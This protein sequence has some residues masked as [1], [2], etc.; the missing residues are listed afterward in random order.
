MQNFMYMLKRMKEGNQKCCKTF[1]LLIDKGTF[2]IFMCKATSNHCAIGFSSS[3]R[4]DMSVENS[5]GRACGKVRGVSGQHG[6]G[7]LR[8]S[9]VIG[10]GPLKILDGKVVVMQAE[11]SVPLWWPTNS[12]EILKQTLARGSD[13]ETTD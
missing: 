5:T 2:I 9:E 7:L 3:A 11:T 13:R 1:A 10:Q 6:L 12:D 8:V 4:T